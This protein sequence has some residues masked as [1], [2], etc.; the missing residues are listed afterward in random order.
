[1]IVGSSSGSG[2]EMLILYECGQIYESGGGKMR[3]D[4]TRSHLS[5][6]SMG[7]DM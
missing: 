3:Q 5:C 4:K 7:R 2:R 1:M 6:M